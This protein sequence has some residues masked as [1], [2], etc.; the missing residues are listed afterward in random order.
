MTDD[1]ELPMPGLDRQ[2]SAPEPILIGGVLATA[3]LFRGIPAEELLAAVDML[4]RASYHYAAETDEWADA[5]ICVDAVADYLIQWKFYHSAIN[6]I[7][8]HKN[9]LVTF[10]QLMDTVLR[11]L[12]ER[13]IA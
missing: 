3:P 6:A 5:R 8:R 9:Q 1:P 10:P 11:R 7:W 12:Y 13:K 4:S 2:Q